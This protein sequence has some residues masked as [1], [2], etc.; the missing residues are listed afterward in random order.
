MTDADDSVYRW[1]RTLL[2]R[3]EEIVLHTDTEPKEVRLAHLE[4]QEIVAAVMV[5]ML[6]EK[7]HLD[8]PDDPEETP[9]HE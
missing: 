9:D 4:D 6:I 1:L 5:K 8:R 2:D 7:Y 3:W